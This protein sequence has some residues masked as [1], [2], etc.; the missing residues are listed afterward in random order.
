MHCLTQKIQ[1]IVKLVIGIRILTSDVISCSEITGRI[2]K[3]VINSKLAQ[4]YKGRC[5]IEILH[6]QCFE[7]PAINLVHI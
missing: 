2:L 1:T 7:K 4:I 5:V 3:D 6:M